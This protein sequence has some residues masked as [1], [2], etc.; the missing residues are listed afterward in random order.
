MSE[1]KGNLLSPRESCRVFSNAGKEREASIAYQT[2]HHNIPQTPSILKNIGEQGTGHGVNIPL[3][4]R[5]VVQYKYPT[6]KV[7]ATPINALFCTLSL[8]NSRSS[9]LALF[10]GGG[11]TGASLSSRTSALRFVLRLLEISPSN[12]RASSTI[13]FALSMIFSGLLGAD[14]TGIFI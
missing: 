3:L 6:S 10:T 8:F 11:S 2:Y 7:A 13:S 14:N 5:R 4:V 12:F 9:T 1:M